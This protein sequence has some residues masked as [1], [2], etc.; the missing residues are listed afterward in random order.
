MEVINEITVMIAVYPLLALTEW[1]SIE[2][3]FE[4]GWAIIGCMGFSIIFNIVFYFSG[5]LVNCRNKLRRFYLKRK[6][7]RIMEE[8]RKRRELE[9]CMKIQ[10]DF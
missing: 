9:Y 5:L 4:A 2:N 3:R 6:N 7:L 1:V 10:S 8:E